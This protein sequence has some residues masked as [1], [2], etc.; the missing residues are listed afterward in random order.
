M[1][2]WLTA[3][4]VNHGEMLT[5]TETNVLQLN[6]DRTVTITNSEQWLKAKLR[7]EESKEKHVLHNNIHLSTT[8]MKIIMNKNHLK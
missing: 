5:S 7:H 8:L 1:R 4:Q 2:K 6:T 3:Q